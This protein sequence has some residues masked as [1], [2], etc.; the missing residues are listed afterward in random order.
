MTWVATYLDPTEASDIYSFSILAY[1]V[2]FT[3]EPWPSVTMQLNDSVRRGYR[4]VIPIN[5][6]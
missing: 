3:R 5:A 6:S 4:P 2:A 1:E